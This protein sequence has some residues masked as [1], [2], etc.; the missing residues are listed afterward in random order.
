MMAG[1]AFANCIDQPR[2]IDTLAGV[3][4]RRSGRCIGA[5]DKFGGAELIPRANQGELG[6][7]AFA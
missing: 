2:S 1:R 5:P 6:V 7:L 3:G 4:L